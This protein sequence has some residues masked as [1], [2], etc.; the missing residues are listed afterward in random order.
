[1]SQAII[2]PEELRKFCTHLKQFESSLKEM[3]AKMNSHARQLA[4]TWRDQEHQKFS[5]EFVQSM[6]PL[7]KLMQSTEKYSLFLTRKAEAA[8]KYIQQR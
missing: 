1:M 5:E 2:K 3:S 7:Q 8:E 4:T 6:Q